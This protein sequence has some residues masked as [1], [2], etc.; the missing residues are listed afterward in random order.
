MLLLLHHA[1][2]PQPIAN[3]SLIDLLM[4]HIHSGFLGLATAGFGDQLVQGAV[5]LELEG[6]RLVEDVN[7]VDLVDGDVGLGNASPVRLAQRVLEHLVQAERRLF[8]GL[9]V[10]GQ[11]FVALHLG[12]VIRSLLSHWAHRRALRLKVLFH[13]LIRAQLHFKLGLMYRLVLGFAQGLLGVVLPAGVLVYPEALDLLAAGQEVLESLVLEVLLGGYD[14]GRLLAS[15]VVL[16]VGLGN[17]GD[18]RALGGE[19]VSAE[20]DGLGV[21]QLGALFELFLGLGFLGVELHHHAHLRGDREEGHR[22]QHQLLQHRVLLELVVLSQVLQQFRCGYRVQVHDVAD[23]EVVDPVVE[24][25]HAQHV[26]AQV[27]VRVQL[28]QLLN[29]PQGVELPDHLPQLGWR[30]LLHYVL[31]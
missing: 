9:E 31:H 23:F 1:W 29:L 2:R 3:V 12:L 28:P 16:G 5:A 20:E 13:E 14:H 19:V 26:A 24:L 18:E 4:R 25:A 30:Y 10:L 17:V 15:Q 8:L 11:L 7:G 22:H 21:P 6:G 27:L